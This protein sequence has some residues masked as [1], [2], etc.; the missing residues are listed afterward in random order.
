MSRA[1]SPLRSIAA[2][3]FAAALLSVPVFAHDDARLHLHVNGTAVYAD[4]VARAPATWF[5]RVPAP[6]WGVASLV[7]AA[8]LLRRR[9]SLA[10]REA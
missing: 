8:T 5:A 7:V 1:P 10:P 9:R 2:G 4:E 6:V 3:V